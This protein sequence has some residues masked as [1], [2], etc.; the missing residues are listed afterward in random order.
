MSEATLEKPVK[1]CL[2]CG[3]PLGPGRDDRKFCNDA[4]RTAFNNK[5]RKEP[6]PE[7]TYSQGDLGGRLAFYQ[8]INSIVRRNRD[9][10]EHLCEIDFRSLEKH[11]LEG[12]GFNFKYFSSEYND[13]EDG[14]YRFCYDYGYQIYNGHMVH[15]LVRTEEILC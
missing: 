14:L 1:S 2:E 11:D 13:P 8:K 6:L 9:I 15:I 7:Q 4:C 3:E 10:M 5:R 12:Y